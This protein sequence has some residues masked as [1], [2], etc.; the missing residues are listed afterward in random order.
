[1]RILLFKECEWRGRKLLFDSVAPESCQYKNSCTSN[2][3]NVVNE[4]A[5]AD[6]KLKKISNEKNNN[7]VSGCR[8]Q[9]LLIIFERMQ[10]N[11]LFCYSFTMT[12]GDSVRWCLERWQ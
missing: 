2:N 4:D 7:N 5:L 12:L 6:K 11:I 10:L 9:E 1:M 8:A 3:N